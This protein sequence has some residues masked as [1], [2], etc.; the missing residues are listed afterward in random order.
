MLYKK[1]RCGMLN[2]IRFMKIYRESKLNNGVTI[3]T[4]ENENAD[5]VTLSVWIKAG[6]RYEQQGERGYAH[7]LEHMLLKGTMS[8]PSPDDVSI[9][10]DRAGGVS[11]ASTT[12]EYIRVF[13]EATKD[14][15]EEMMGLL[16]DMVLNP[17]IDK[18]ILENEKKVVLQEMHQQKNNDAAHLWIESSKKVF[19]NNPLSQNPMGDEKQIESASASALKEYYQRFFIG[20]RIVVVATGALVHDRVRSIADE[21]LGK[22]S[23]AQDNGDANFAPAIISGT[24]FVQGKSDQTYLSF[25]FLGPRASL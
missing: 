8:K 23:G 3:I 24:L 4:G 25:N 15:F 7:L 18:E 12:T 19:G 20:D 2:R 6:S 16:M 17:L 13:I 21:N 22:I 10:V 1:K 11:N 14:R 9:V 5:I